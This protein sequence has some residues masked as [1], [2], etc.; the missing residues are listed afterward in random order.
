MARW[1]NAQDVARQRLASLVGQGLPPE[2][3]G[4]R[5]LEAVSLAVPND[6]Q[7]LFTVDPGSMLF[8]RLIAA[9]PGDGAFRQT[10]LRDI[11][12]RSLSNR[13]FDPSLLL[14]AGVSAVL[15]H[16]TQERSI[17]IPAT[18]LTPTTSRDHTQIFR[19]AVTPVGGSLRVCLFANGRPIAMMDTVRRETRRPLRPT[20]LAF[21]RLLAPTMGRALAA[22]R[23]RELAMAHTEDPRPSD[24]GIVLLDAD[25]RVR[26][27]TPAGEAW[28]ALLRHAHHDES[29]HLPASVWSAVAGLLHQKD[30]ATDVPV[31]NVVIVST[32]VGRVRIEAS[33]GG[34]DGSIAVVIASLRTA[35][36]FAVPIWWPLTRQEQ[37]VV[38]LLIR[39]AANQEIATALWISPHTVE[40][41]LGHAYEKL[42]V[43]SRGQLLARLFRD[44]TLPAL[45]NPSAVASTTD[46][47]APPQVPTIR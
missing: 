36:Q 22:A 29:H 35:E 10:W 38:S 46:P 27:I 39:G 16:D 13:Y 12:P 9:S 31:S 24:S 17:G 25:R 33:P 23:A 40:S 34:E 18:M 30:C 4:R 42:G 47:P 6:G 5:V 37:E 45:T 14:R 11:Y 7:R 41:H 3:L 1:S 15:Y 43:R 8:D 32:P 28:L 20:D 44:A 19:D 2:S 21:L 26:L